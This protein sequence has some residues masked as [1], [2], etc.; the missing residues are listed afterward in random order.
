MSL[1]SLIAYLWNPK[2][3]LK[4]RPQQP[5][6]KLDVYSTE[7]KE[8]QVET[9][10]SVT[11]LT[12][13]E[14][15]TDRILT[16]NKDGKQVEEILFQ[17][18]DEFT[19]TSSM[20][21]RMGDS[22]DIKRFNEAGFLIEEVS[23]DPWGDTE[24]TKYFYDENHNLEKVIQ[25]DEDTYTVEDLIYKEG[26]L[27]KIETNND[28]GGSL[29]R[30]FIYDAKGLLEK[31]IRMQNEFVNMEEKYFYN[32]QNQLVREI[33]ESISRIK[34][35]KNPMMITEFEYHSNGQK[36]SECF[37]IIDSYKGITKLKSSEYYSEEGLLLKEESHDFIEEK[38]TIDEYRYE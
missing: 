24:T 38:E 5:W 10:L 37:S 6:K 15:K 33:H 27:H 28:D 8:E 21:H 11:T 25:K 3:S 1:E 9:Y 14:G 4:K 18:P 2:V 32:E 29:F 19:E 23:L 35:G 31:V 7:K 13:A 16:F 20:S 26:K 34:D 17:Y 12:N 36:K 30:G 22:K